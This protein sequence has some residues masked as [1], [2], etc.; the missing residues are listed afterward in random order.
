VAGVVVAHKRPRGRPRKY[1]VAD[2][3]AA[4]AKDEAAA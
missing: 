4:A 1:S 2:P 3:F